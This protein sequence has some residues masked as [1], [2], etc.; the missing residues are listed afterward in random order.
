MLV[1]D[2]VSESAVN[3]LRRENAQLILSACAIFVPRRHP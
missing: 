3:Y 1:R 2:A